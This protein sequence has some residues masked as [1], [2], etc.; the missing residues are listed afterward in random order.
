MSDSSKKC[1]CIQWLIIIMTLSSSL[2]SKCNVSTSITWPMFSYLHQGCLAVPS[3]LVHLSHLSTLTTILQKLVKDTF[4][5]A[6]L[7]SLMKHHIEMSESSLGV[8]LQQICT[9]YP[10]FF[11]LNARESWCTWSSSI[12]L[13]THRSRY[14]RHTIPAWTTTWTLVTFA[15]RYTRKAMW[16]WIT[17]WACRQVLKE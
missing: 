3:L 9:N 4:C 15:A 8:S 1:L 10:T 11:T 12:S 7:L 17:C 14:S 16:S 6:K 13:H 2:L 5:V